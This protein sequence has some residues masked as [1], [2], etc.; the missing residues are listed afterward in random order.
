MIDLEYFLVAS[1]GRRLLL[2]TCKHTSSAEL[3]DSGGSL[4]LISLY[5]PK[6]EKAEI[7]R[8]AGLEPRTS[9]VRLYR[10]NH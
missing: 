5:L 10:L 9:F 3:H 1:C 7:R 8:L 2:L 6:A 4:R